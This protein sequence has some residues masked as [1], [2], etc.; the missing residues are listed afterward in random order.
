MTRPTSDL[1]AIVAAVSVRHGLSKAGTREI[2]GS[3]LEEVEVAVWREGRVILRDFA[4]FTVKEVGWRD[5]ALNDTGPVLPHRRVKVRVSE[6][7][8]RRPMVSP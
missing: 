1:D 3:F 8:R 5:Q 4:T 6:S 2:I 7:W